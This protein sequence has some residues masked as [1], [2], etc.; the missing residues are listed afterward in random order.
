MDT[1]YIPSK[2]P[3]D[4]KPFLAK[5]EHWEPGHSAMT[6]A[7]CWQKAN[8]FPTSVKKVFKNSKYTLFHGVELLFAFPEYKVSLPGGNACSQNDI[9]IIAKSGNKLISITVEGKVDEPF[10]TTIEKWRKDESEG[11]KERLSFLLQELGLEYS[12]AIEA[13]QY[14]LLHRTV[15]AILEAKKLNA[16]NALMLV[17]SFSQDNK[18]FDEYVRFVRLFDI[19]PEINGLYLGKKVNGIDL[20]FAWVKGEKEYLKNR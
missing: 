16:G 7:Y 11:K 9:F 12:P 1:F 6:L 14:Q 18:W 19:E 8:D 17:H 2:K 15:S 10:D 4:W 13:I 20:Y 5:P 3:E